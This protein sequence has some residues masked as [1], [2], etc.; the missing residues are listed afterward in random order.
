MMFAARS[1]NHFTIIDCYHAI[2]EVYPNM[3]AC[4]S[5]TR[6]Q[7]LASTQLALPT[8]K[9]FLL[10]LYAAAKF[11]PPMIRCGY[12]WD[13]SNVTRVPEFNFRKWPDFEFG[14]GQTRPAGRYI[15]RQSDTKGISQTLP[16]PPT[17]H[18]TQLILSACLLQR[19]KP[20][21]APSSRE[22]MRRSA[23]S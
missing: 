2:C 20:R 6:A 22:C 19:S 12:L 1:A 11:P 9:S 14:N 21:V 17:Y 5:Q 23:M 18:Y 8:D 7:Q 3:C 15:F 16:L 4:E 13:V 10:K